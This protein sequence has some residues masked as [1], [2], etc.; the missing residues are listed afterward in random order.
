MGVVEVGET[1]SLTVE[2]GAH[3]VLEC[4]QAH[5]PRNLHLKG[6]YLLVGRE[7]SDGKHGKRK[8]SRIA[9]SLTPPPD[10]APQYSNMGCPILVNT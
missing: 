8:A 7:G 10:T 9:P 4:T 3:G 6:H 5:P 2:S 1:A